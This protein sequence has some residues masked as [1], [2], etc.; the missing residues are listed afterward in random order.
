VDSWDDGGPEVVDLE[1]G[2]LVSG[3]EMVVH[4]AYFAGRLTPMPS[5]D[6]DNT[7]THVHL[8]AN[9]SAQ[10]SS[11]W[12]GSQVVENQSPETEKEESEKED[13]PVSL[14]NAIAE[15]GKPYDSRSGA[16]H[17]VR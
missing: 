16:Q 2:V 7:N 8:D 1:E 14:P 15:H 3:M 11:A 5:S 10:G 17:D 12:R 6:T 9:V 13:S 4:D